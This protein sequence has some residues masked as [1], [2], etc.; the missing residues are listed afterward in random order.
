MTYLN[1]SVIIEHF[2]IRQTSH[3]YTL[4]FYQ[5]FTLYDAWKGMRLYI[6]V[7]IQLKS[8]VPQ[9]VSMIY[10]INNLSKIKIIHINIMD[11][12]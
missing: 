3:V 9:I 7:K 2:W 5:Q 11:L 8:S 10:L 1:P 12:I 6:V 4:I